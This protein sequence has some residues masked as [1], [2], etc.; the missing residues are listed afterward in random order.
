M[1]RLCFPTPWHRPAYVFPRLQ[2][3][4]QPFSHNNFAHF[5]FNLF[6]HLFLLSIFHLTNIP[7]GPVLEAEDSKDRMCPCPWRALSWN[8]PVAL[9]FPAPQA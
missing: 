2:A 3:G 6:L 4:K 1:G 7:A 9:P 5:I 8:M